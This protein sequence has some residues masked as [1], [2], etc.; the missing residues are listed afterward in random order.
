MPLQQSYFDKWNK[1]RLMTTNLVKI[2]PDDADYT[3][4]P[5]SDMKT[6]GELI[7][8]II[9]ANY[10]VLNKFF[11][12]KIE[13]PTI[14]RNGPHNKKSLFPYLEQSSSHVKELFNILSASDLPQGLASGKNDRTSESI[15]RHLEDHEVHHSAQLKMYLKLLNIETKDIKFCK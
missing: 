1:I 4:K 9:F 3:W 7:T 11:D 14:I 2:I 13:V 10:L 12:Q 8:H 15:I 5:H 6:L